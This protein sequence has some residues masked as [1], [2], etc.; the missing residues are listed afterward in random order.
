MRYVASDRTVE[1]TAIE[2]ING[3][4]STQTTPKMRK[5][6][7][8]FLRHSSFPTVEVQQLAQAS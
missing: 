8:I 2:N 5:S 7:F 6:L 4:K 1:I 3:A